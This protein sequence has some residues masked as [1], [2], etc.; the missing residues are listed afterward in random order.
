M[1]SGLII[2]PFNKYGL[3]EDKCSEPIPVTHIGYDVEASYSFAKITQTLTFKNVQ[4]KANSANFYFPRSLT[5]SYSELEI[6]YG[7]LRVYGSVKAKEAAIAAYNEAKAAGKTAALI[8]VEGPKAGLDR[9]DSMRVQLT[10]LVPGI[11]VTVKFGIVQELTRNANRWTLKIPSTITNLYQPCS[12]EVGKSLQ[13]LASVPN[14]PNLLRM[15]EVLKLAKRP[16]EVKMVYQPVNWTYSLK[17][18]TTGQ[19]YQ[20]DCATHPA[21]GYAGFDFLDNSGSGFHKYNLSHT[22]SPGGFNEDFLFHYRDSNFE[23]AVFNFAHW[24]QN[25]QTPYAL[26]ILFDPFAQQPEEL[27]EK[28]AELNDDFKGEYLFVLDRS[29]S[30]GGEP[31]EM[32]V[33]SL[34]IG[35]RSLPEGSYFNVVSFGS[36]HKYLFAESRLTDDQSV[37]EAIAE[38][39]KY[40]ADMEGTEIF[41]PIQDIFSRGQVQGLP[42]IIIVMTDGQVGN[43][44]SIIQYI[45]ANSIFHR[46]FTLGIGSNFSE[47]LVNGMAKAGNG[48]TAAVNDPS[49]I[50]DAV[51]G[52]LEQSFTNPTKVENFQYQGVKVVYSDPIIGGACCLFKQQALSI[53]AL[54]S[55][56][57]T[58]QEMVVTFETVHPDGTR[59]HHRVPLASELLMKTNA[60]H[61]NLANKYSNFSDSNSSKS[62]YRNGASGYQDLVELGVNNQ[63]LN[64]QT[65]FVAIFE[66]N[67]EAPANA[68]RIE[69]PPVKNE[70][71]RSSYQIYV[72]TLTGKTITLDV[73][74][75]MTIEDIKEKIQDKEG[76]PPDQQ[77][78]IFAG[79]QLEDYRTLQDYNILEESTLH[80]VLR[81]RGGGFAAKLKIRVLKTG[82]TDPEVWD[83]DGGMKWEALFEKIAKKFSIPKEEIVLRNL[84]KDFSYQD[85]K[86]EYINFAIPEAGVPVVMDLRSIKDPAPPASAED[87]MMS[88]ITLQSSNGSWKFSPEIIEALKNFGWLSTQPEPTDDKS[89]TEFMILSFETHLKSF[90]GKWKLLIKKAK[91]FVASATI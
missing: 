20:W 78:L 4:F 89:L 67:P 44:Q 46:V 66:V 59:V 74:D 21:L 13:H 65:G 38:V 45:E 90:E 68:A 82:K 64:K 60:V 48:S 42:K 83:V 30:M 31:I 6:F 52:L 77:R 88:L 76:I 23:S 58:G 29:G 86:E 24:P 73:E 72:K 49:M 50:T 63:V 87:N 9:S 43:T 40:D 91:K 37:A 2:L 79:S 26:N 3:Y 5:S 80:L 51:V 47:E 10:N 28:L 35:I 36:T 71:V 7:N 41:R 14:I 25:Q 27:K 54:F 56:I 15:M 32:A 34:I 19:D 70:K 1:E 81:L 55:E 8:T 39:S 85:K 22:N 11:D 53:S 12:L 84:G 57:H 18:F 75:Q 62:R 69:L 61:K 16:C 33:Q 17:V